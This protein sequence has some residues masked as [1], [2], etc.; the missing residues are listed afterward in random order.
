MTASTANHWSNFKRM[1]AVHAQTDIVR[2]CIVED[3]LWPNR[4]DHREEFG[5]SPRAPIVD[6]IRLIDLGIAS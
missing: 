1:S 3:A 6:E 2:L 4:S 5:P